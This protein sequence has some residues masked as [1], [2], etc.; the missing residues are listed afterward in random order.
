MST[1]HQV[2]Q[3]LKAH[4]WT[5]TKIMATHAPIDRE[6]R[7]CDTA[8]PHPADAYVCWI[9]EA[10]DTEPWPTRELDEPV[11]RHAIAPALERAEHEDGFVRAY[12]EVTE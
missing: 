7:G 12:V 9:V 3:V 10:E 4:G 8:D 2:R 5:D 6:C 1:V 11:C